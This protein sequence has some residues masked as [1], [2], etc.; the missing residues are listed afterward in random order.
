MQKITEIKEQYTTQRY[1]KVNGER[2]KID[3]VLT[4]YKEVKYVTGWPRLGHF[5]LD[6]LFFTAFAFL[7][8]VFVGLIF[9]FLGQNSL[10]AAI[11]FVDSYELYINYFLLQP[12]FYF[13]FEFA[14]QASPAKL[15][16][17][18]IVVDEYGNKPTMKQFFIR[19]IS[20]AIPFEPLSCFGTLGWHDTA[21][22]T[23]VI[24][25]K[26]LEELK[27]SLQIAQFDMN[28]KSEP[29]NAGS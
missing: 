12:I 29:N 17:K 19:S 15:I 2:V 24:R 16:L 6:R 25:K 5:L 8:Y 23:F 3:K 18:R 26:D 20:R 28:L 11:Q 27:L 9:G 13:V 14:L 1:E 10:K 21:S 4:R 22:D 7:F